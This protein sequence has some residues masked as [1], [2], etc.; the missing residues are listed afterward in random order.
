[1]FVEDCINSILNQ[2]FKDWELIL[3]DDGSPDRSGSICDSFAAGDDRIRVFH[4]TNSG[5]SAA[6]NMGICQA[7][8]DYL[9]FIDSDDLV[10]PDFLDSFWEKDENA[11][12]YLQG[13][14]LVDDRMIVKNIVS[15]ENVLHL[16]IEDYRIVYMYAEEEHIFNSPWARLFKRQIIVDNNVRFDS[17]LSF[18]EDHVFSLQYLLYVRKLSYVSNSGYLY[19]RRKQESLTT[20]YIPHSMF[21]NYAKL[22]YSLRKQNCENLGIT[23]DRFL[24][25][26]DA[27]RNIYILRAILSLISEKRMLHKVKSEILYSYLD[28]LDRS[29]GVKYM[30][31]PYKVIFAICELS[32]FPCLMTFIRIYLVINEMR[33][34]IRKKIK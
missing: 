8:G 4:Q 20:A 34:N 25:F 5:V 28:A 10:E 21:I 18:G 2:S 1:M 22:S 14:K 24:K 12:L 26:I 33:L 29:V 30:S 15:F 31:G 3:V 7:K 19:V 16:G 27:E 17:S 6:R 9:C 23:N 32:P 11:D 13:V